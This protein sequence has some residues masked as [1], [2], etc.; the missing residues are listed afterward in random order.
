MVFRPMR[1]ASAARKY[2]IEK[3]PAT[4]AEVLAVTP[5][6]AG[7]KLESVYLGRVNRVARINGH[8]VREKSRFSVSGSGSTPHTLPFAE[9]HA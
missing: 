5:Q 4:P 9:G 1:K 8:A 3:R 6:Q 7:L 2:R